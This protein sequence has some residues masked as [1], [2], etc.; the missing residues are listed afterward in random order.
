MGMTCGAW[1]HLWMQRDVFFSLLIFQWYCAV[2]SVI[3]FVCIELILLLLPFSATVTVEVL[4]F[5]LAK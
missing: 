2:L 5:F 4:M 3:I 1:D